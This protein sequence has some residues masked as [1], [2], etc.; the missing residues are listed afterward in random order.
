MAALGEDE[1]TKIVERWQAIAREDAAALWQECAADMR[2]LVSEIRRLRK[3]LRL[4]IIDAANN[5]AEANDLCDLLVWLRQYA[6]RDEGRH[7]GSTQDRVVGKP[8]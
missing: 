2:R 3:Q 5:E 1:L 6:I 8:R 4:A 7:R